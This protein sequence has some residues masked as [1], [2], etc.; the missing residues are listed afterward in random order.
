[1]LDHGLHHLSTA[2]NLSRLGK[3]DRAVVRSVGG[4]PDLRSR[5]QEMGFTPGCS[6]RLVARAAFGGPLAFQVRGTLV[7]LRRADAACIEV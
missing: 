6:V 5:L 1:M 7:A 2:S 4:H 3:G